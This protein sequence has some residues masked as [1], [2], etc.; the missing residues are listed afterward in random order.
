MNGLSLTGMYV[1]AALLIGVGLGMSYFIVRSGSSRRPEGGLEWSVLVLS[2]LVALM[3]AGFITLTLTGEVTSSPS[4]EGRTVVG[5]PAPTLRFRLVETNQEKRLNDYKGKVVILNLWATWCPPCLEELPELNRLQ[6]KYRSDGLVVV[7]ISDERRETLQ[8]FERE[9][10]NLQTVSG[11]LPPDQSWPAP[12][13]KVR[14]SR[15]M[16]FII[17]RNGR[18]QNLWRGAAD[19]S[20]FERA[21]TPY[22]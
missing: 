5:E 8:R 20:Q 18:I 2:F 16:S 22:L 3:G 14:S 1:L 21:V 13:D 10:V 11:Y 9:K 19:F 7:T 4:H 17:D 6:E 15:P 12:Y